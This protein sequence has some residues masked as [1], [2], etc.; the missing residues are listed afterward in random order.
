MFSSPVRKGF[1][2]IGFPWR[3]HPAHSLQ[4][5]RYFAQTQFRAETAVTELRMGKPQIILP[6][7]DVI[8]KLVAQGESD[9]IRLSIRTDQINS[10]QLR[11]FTAIQSKRWNW[12]RRIGCYDRA[13]VPFVKPFRLGANFSRAPV[14][15]L[16]DRA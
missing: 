15:P 16:R 5:L 9:P 3:K 2:Q 7:G 4:I 10:D 8:R 1:S 14:C 12:N 13:A 6:L 11:F